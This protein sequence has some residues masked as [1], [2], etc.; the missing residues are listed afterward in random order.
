MSTGTIIAVCTSRNKGTPKNEVG[1]GFLEIGFGLKGDAHGGD[2]HRQVSLLSI[3]QIENMKAK[4]LEV[5][6]G[7]FAENLTTRDFDLPSVRVGDRLRVGESAVLEI[8]QIGKECHT[9]CA[10]YHKVGECIMPEQ[11]VFAKVL[12]EGAVKVGD[13]IEFQFTASDDK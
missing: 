8:T 10:I 3:E 12:E 2:W 1:S 4:G 7:S 9:R 11:G 6:P 5:G 13:S